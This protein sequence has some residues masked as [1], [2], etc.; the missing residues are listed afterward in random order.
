MG[1]RPS[2]KRKVQVLL[3]R[4]QALKLISEGRSVA[5]IA[6][7]LR[8]RERSARRH[9]RAALETESLYPSAITAGQAGVTDHQKRFL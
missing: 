9:M 8:L 3:R 4:K 6:R 2:L 5:A 1:K 7:E